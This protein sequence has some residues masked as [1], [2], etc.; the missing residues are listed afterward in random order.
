MLSSVPIA[1]QG[2]IP[3]RNQV[4]RSIVQAWRPIAPSLL[5]SGGRLQTR[6]LTSRVPAEMACRIELAGEVISALSKV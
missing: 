2:D 5:P 4:S 3:R 1:R 6:Q